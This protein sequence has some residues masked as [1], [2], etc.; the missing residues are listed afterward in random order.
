MVGQEALLYDVWVAFKAFWFSFEIA[1]SPT[2]PQRQTRPALGHYS[3]SRS[4]SVPS[5]SGVIASCGVYSK[6]WTAWAP[7]KSSPG[8]N[9]FVSDSFP[10][11]LQESFLMLPGWVRC[12]PFPLR[13][14][15][16]LLQTVP[17]VT[18]WALVFLPKQTEYPTW[19]FASSV[20]DSSTSPAS[21]ASREDFDEEKAG[22]RAQRSTHRPG[23]LGKQ[24]LETASAGR[25]I[26]NQKG[27]SVYQR[28]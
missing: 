25:K 5:V 10:S 8:Q 16:V 18:T 14:L 6:E 9:P 21:D 27:N 13:R 24:G 23:V 22:R 7:I 1:T 3:H 11:S 19:D 26:S 12:S 20:C 2:L 17:L 15:H 4:L 28:R